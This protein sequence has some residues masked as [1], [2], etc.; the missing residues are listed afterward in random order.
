MNQI[1][2]QKNLRR[3]YDQRKEPPD[4]ADDSAGIASRTNIDTLLYDRKYKLD[5]LIKKTTTLICLSARFLPVARL[6][7]QTTLN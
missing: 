5:N 6:P 4:R 3:N 7:T 2:Q 1:A